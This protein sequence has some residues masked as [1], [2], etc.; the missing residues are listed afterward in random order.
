MRMR[1]LES[2]IVLL[3]LVLILAVQAAG[4]T[5]IRIGIDQNARAAI[6]EELVVGERVF[7][8][9][10][11][12]YAHNL[13]QGA[14]VLASDYGFKQAIASDD[15]ETIV[16]ALANHGERIGASHA[17]LVAA[18]RSIKASTTGQL[19]GSFER[20]IV[21]LLDAA[22]NGDGAS[23]NS[24]IDDQPYQVVV[25]PVKAPVTIGWVA[26][27]FPV[28]RQLATDMRELSLMHISVFISGMTG[29]W[30]ATASTL[31]AA[32]ATELARQMERIGSRPQF[33]SQI[34][35]ADADYSAQVLIFAK[36]AK[37]TAA[38]VL[39]HS[40]SDAIAPYQRLQLILLVLTALGIMVTFAGSMFMA[41]R[42]TRPLR[43]LSDIAK[44]LG[45]GDYR[46][47]ID[48]G[49]DDEIG[50]LSKAFES[51][52]DGIARREAEI[53]RL[54][55]WDTL[56]GLPNRV[57][58]V[59]MLNEAIL[60]A[61]Q[62]DDQCH[63]LMMDLDGFKNVND[64]LGH[65]VG[66]ALLQHVAQRLQGQ[67]GGEYASRVARLG[68][69]EFAILVPRM[70]E[71]T[72]RALAARILKSLEIPI[73]IDEHTIDLGAGIG[74]AGFPRHGANA[75]MVLS[76]AE[77]A[78][79]AAKT[80][81][82]EAVVYDPAIDKSSE[83]NLSLLGDLRR[84]AERGEFR[85]YVQPKVMLDSGEVVGM[86]ALVRWAH[87]DKGLIFPDNFIPFAEKSGFIRVLT[88]WMLDQSAALCSQM[89]KQGFPLRISVN[90][91]TRDLVDLDLPAKFGAIL[92]RHAIPSSRFCLEITESAIMDDP[93]RAQQ[94]LEKLHSMG[95]D[96]SIDDFG[97]G[98]SS[99][100]YLKR[101]PVGELKIDKSFVMK[102][103]EDADD[104]K[105]VR[106]TIDLGHNMGLKVVAEGVENEAVWE[107]L[108]RMGCDIG[109]GYFIS[110][111]MPA[112]RLAEWLAN[113]TPPVFLAGQSLSLSHTH[114]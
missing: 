71:D 41:R 112:E 14:R 86:E 46:G 57:Q 55:Y 62:E 30:T 111:P 69:D 113:W 47:S 4:F 106:S 91:S 90:I 45:A 42:I 105:I 93:V 25:V 99:L 96:L 53:G 35:I 75:E 31:P 60:Q 85:L 94:T 74:I 21:E 59:A 101:L 83:Q 28:A 54:A 6:Q 40:I 102:M 27:A 23:N 98:Y 110:R 68:G 107:L 87:P 63:V 82:N 48:I 84:A 24:I 104:T 95:V 34:R 114:Q 7:R 16:S 12:L 92:D 80:G 88:Q 5:A 18:D 66:D 65:G 3:F 89:E 49:K 78:M 77:V 26:M 15:S 8:R 9:L 22:E 51:M 72:V 76:R 81:G 58:F 29:S 32:A 61:K 11:D 79:Y 37:Q 52:R 13:T 19:V 70:H 64:V 100:A 38:V 43:R 103:E 2:R 10:L 1:S 20:S 36:D 44:R 108:A 17:V 39:Q 109:Q 33:L 73:S 67:I 97:T 56:T 50:E